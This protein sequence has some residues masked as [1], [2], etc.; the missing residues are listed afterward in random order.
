MLDFISPI[1][2]LDIS[3][4]E[5]NKTEIPLFT[6]N[7]ELPAGTLSA[8]CSGDHDAYAVVFNAYHAS[9]KRFLTIMTRSEDDAQELTQE[10]FINLWEKREKINPESNIKGF[11][12]TTAKFYMFNY[13]K[14]KQVI[15]KYEQYKS[16]EIDFATSPDDIV[17]AKELSMLIEIIIA[18]MPKQQQKVFQLKYD[19]CKTNAEIA[20]LLNISPETVKV[21]LTRGRNELRKAILELIALFML[22]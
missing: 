19:Q 4:E 17:I 10:V 11:L 5:L 6:Q 3:L 20:S 1:Q 7:S 16:D 2:D 21:H 18:R 14:H 12:Y 8:L 15:L 13:F 9:I 22:Q